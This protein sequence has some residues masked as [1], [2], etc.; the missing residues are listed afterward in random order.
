MRT[1]T[2]ER[3]ERGTRKWWKS[4]GK[5]FAQKDKISFI[6]DGVVVIEEPEL[7]RILDCKYV[8]IERI[9]TS[10]LSDEKKNWLPKMLSSEWLIV[11]L[12]KPHWKSGWE[13]I[14]PETYKRKP[15][16]DE[17][18]GGIYE[19]LQCIKWTNS[20]FYSEKYKALLNRYFER[21]S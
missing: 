13:A 21:N 8:W 18:E 14:R 15:P 5:V 1:E 16:E 7:R 12:G 2:T 4:L 19:L 20:R 17:L 9:L 6:P 10:D 11:I 3:Y